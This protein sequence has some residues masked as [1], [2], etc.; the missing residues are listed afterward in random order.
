MSLLSF[1]IRYS[2]FYVRY[3]FLVP[4]CPAYGQANKLKKYSRYSGN[5]KKML[6]ERQLG[7]IFITEYIMKFKMAVHSRSLFLQDAGPGPIEN[8][9]KLIN[10]Y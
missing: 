6:T 1:D 4:A 5:R 8:I 10:V 3:S 7:F 9:R 2:W